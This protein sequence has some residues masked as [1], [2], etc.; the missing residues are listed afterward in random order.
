M[1][2]RWK[3]K[4]IIKNLKSL[5][6]LENACTR[7]VSNTDLSSRSQM[8]SARLNKLINV[9]KRDFFRVRYEDIDFAHFPA[10]MFIFIAF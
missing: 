10:N 6:F 8:Y 3:L 5:F 4:K 7:C 1:Q 2:I 9:K